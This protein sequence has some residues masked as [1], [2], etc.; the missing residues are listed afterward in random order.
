MDYYYYCYYYIQENSIP[1]LPV[2]YL[3]SSYAIYMSITNLLYSLLYQVVAIVPILLRNFPS[4]RSSGFYFGLE[5][6]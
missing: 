1:L 3:S 5:V 2:K 4:K 6:Q